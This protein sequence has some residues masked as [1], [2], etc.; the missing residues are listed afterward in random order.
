[1]IL[2]KNISKTFY[3]GDEIVR[4][5]QDVSLHIRPNEFVAVCGPSGSGKTTL[6]NIMGC[7]DNADS[8]TYY[9]DGM[10]IAECNDRQLSD[11]RSLKIGFVFQQFN[12][13]DQMNALENVELPLIYQK[14]GARERIERAKE[15]LNMVGLSN[16]IHHKPSQ[17]SGGQQQRVAIAR[18]LASN[19]KVILA[20]EPTGNLDSKSGEDVMHL[21]GGLTEKN[22]TVVLI[23]HNPEVAKM[24]HRTIFVHDGRIYEEK[25]GII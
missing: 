7:L 14:I 19:A 22:C 9:L 23:T 21:I 20:D 24:A 13:L 25:E 8:G 10:D 6:M 3:V 1:M 15:A 4:A 11:I 12:L 16:R 5:L 17:L 2:M 18:A